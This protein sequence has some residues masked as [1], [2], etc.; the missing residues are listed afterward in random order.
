MG[1]VASQ[2]VEIFLNQESNQC[3]LHS[4]LTS[5]PP[6]K[7]CTHISNVKEGS[8]KMSHQQLSGRIKI[9]NRHIKQCP[10]TVQMTLRQNQ[11]KVAISVFILQKK[12]GCRFLLRKKSLFRYQHPLPP[13]YFP[14]NEQLADFLQWLLTN[15]FKNQNGGS[16]DLCRLVIV[17]ELC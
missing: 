16:L 10:F 17:F 4:K 7:S 13:L 1:L 9:Y 15:P 11:I 6:G 5:R 3:P 2:D 12:I 8:L 14:I